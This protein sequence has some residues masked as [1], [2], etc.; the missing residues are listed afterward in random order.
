MIDAGWEMGTD[1]TYRVSQLAPSRWRV[2]EGFNGTSLGTGTFKVQ[3]M[4]KK[5]AS[6]VRSSSSNHRLII[7]NKINMST[8]SFRRYCCRRRDGHPCGCG[9]GFGHPRACSGAFSHQQAHSARST[10]CRS[11]QWQLRRRRSTRWRRG[12]GRR[13]GGERIYEEDVGRMWRVHE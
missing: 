10:H 6:S 7:K 5:K 8:E 11:C 9:G 3:G 4:K 1:H 12:G 2:L 13:G